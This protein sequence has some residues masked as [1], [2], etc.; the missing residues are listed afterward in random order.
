[1]KL[2]INCKEAAHKC[3]KAQYREATIWEKMKLIIHKLYCS[4]C[5][6]YSSKNT[7]L[8]TIIENSKPEILPKNQKEFMKE[9]IR[10]ELTK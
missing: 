7:K 8:T 5:R 4:R 1:M 3:D 10:K 2:F 6:D 9:Q